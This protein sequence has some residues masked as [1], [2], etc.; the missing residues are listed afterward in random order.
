MLPVSRSIPSPDGVADL[1]RRSY[2]LDVTGCSLVRSL[3]NDVYVV[4]TPTGRYVLKIYHHGGWS[5]DEVAWEYELVAH[6]RASGIPTAE[7]VRLLDGSFVGELEAPEGVRPFGLT[8]FV[9]GSKPSPPFDDALYR[10]YGVLLARF[11]QAADSFATTR[12]R[13]AFGLEQTLDAPLPQVLDALADRPDDRRVVADMAAIARARI[14]ELAGRGLSWGIRHGDVTLDNIHASGDGLT[15]HDFDLAG[16]GWRIADLAPCLATDF[17][18]AFL[19]GY[20]SVR[21]VTQTDL[22]ALPWLDVI[23]RIGNLRFH[24]VDK[25]A[26]R[27][28]ES[29]GEGW[30]DRELSALRDAATALP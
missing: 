11:H 13:R 23:G 21:P 2:G 7:G 5:T 18:E 20:T 8:A 25:V 6:V 28:T 14:E 12:H 9:D 30:V 15:L 19:A 22:A 24:L 16:Q 17:A 4:T 29:I 1:V 26:L 3:V 27:G 10:S